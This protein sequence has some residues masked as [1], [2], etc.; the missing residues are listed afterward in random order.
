MAPLDPAEVCVLLTPRQLGGHEV[1]LFGWLGDATRDLNLRPAILAPTAA[2]AAA[3][4]GAGLSGSLRGAPARWPR[5]A[6]LRE[7]LQEWLRAPAH[8]PVL[9]AP[10]VLHVDAWLLAAAVMLRRPLWV[11]VPM[12]FTAERMGFRF[13]RLRDRLIAP[14]LRGVDRWIVIDERQAALL[15]ES[16]QLSAPVHVLPNQA[17]VIGTAPPLP[18][19]LAEGRLR[20]AWVGRFEPRQKGLDWLAAVLQSGVG[21]TD[22]WRFQGRGA[23]N[24]LLH[25]LSRA[26]GT[27]RVTVHEH[28]PLDD[29]LAASDLLLLA[30][31]F[32]GVPLVALEAI[33]RGWPV[34]ATR[35]CGLDEWLPATS[36]YDFG[37]AAGLSRA[38]DA[39]RTAAARQ[40]AAAHA[41]ARWQAAGAE[42]RYRQALQGIVDALQCQPAPRPR[43]TQSGKPC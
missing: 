27:Q 28:A 24:T 34:V 25:E 17:W 7:L 3:C 29:A 4:A 10:G 21:G 14:W 5:L 6:L 12:A 35:G 8:R 15:R 16:W 30:S 9:L 33:A 26:L 36:L 19:P 18:E 22:H 23:G 32:E 37:D 31:R 43:L 41:R 1:A 42:S 40:A 38:L 2:L 20:I 11:Y 13:G 39:L